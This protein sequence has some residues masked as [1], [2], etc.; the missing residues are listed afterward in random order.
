[1][2]DVRA[3]RTLSSTP[4]YTTRHSRGHA[5]PSPPPPPTV[6]PQPVAAVP[7]AEEPR[8][9]ERV[10]CSCDAVTTHTGFATWGLRGTDP[11]RISDRP[12]GSTSDAREKQPNA[13][14]GEEI[15]PVARSCS[16]QLSQAWHVTRRWCMARVQRVN[17]GAGSQL[18]VW[19]GGKFVL[20][21]V[22]V[23]WKASD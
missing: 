3:L 8:I 5:A 22:G 11:F 4:S 19:V 14:S 7:P 15:S 16:I 1:M 17:V 20:R 21:G 2:T 12:L 18:C 23:I 13:A 9:D 10:A 6:P